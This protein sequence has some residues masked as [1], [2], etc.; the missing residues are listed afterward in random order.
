[1]FILVALLCGKREVHFLSTVVR[2][3]YGEGGFCLQLGRRK[4]WGGVCCERVRLASWE[5]GSVS[6]LPVASL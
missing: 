5:N 4:G 2:L 6:F 1:V 3:R